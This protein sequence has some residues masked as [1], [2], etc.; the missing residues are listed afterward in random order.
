MDLSEGLQP[1]G[2]LQSVFETKKDV[3]KRKVRNAKS[4]AENLHLN[5]HFRPFVS[6]RAIKNS[7]RSKGAGKSD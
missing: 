1:N 5:V 6:W 4:R 3:K 2:V 7:L